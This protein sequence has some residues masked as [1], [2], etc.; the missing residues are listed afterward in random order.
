MRLG[1]IAGAAALCLA[2]L[3]GSAHA[4]E[5]RGRIVG[6]VVD[7]SGAV[8]P[9]VS[10]TV[11]GP[12]L[13]QPQTATS[14]ADGTYRFPSLPSG[15]YTVTYEM[16]GFQTTRREGIRVLLN[17]TFTVDA[18]LQLA[19]VQEALTVT[20]E[21][22]TVD[23]KTTS[24]GTSFTKELL[25]D[26]PNARDVWAAMAQ[27][28]GFQM[29]G[30]DVGGSH[31]GTQTGYF[32][33]GIDNQNK[34]LLEGI[35][36]TES[37]NAN[38]GYF[39]FGSFEEF[40]LGGAGNL[41][42]Q[43]GPGALMNI[44]VKSGG[45]QF[46]GEVY[47]DYENDGTIADNVPDAFRAPGGVG[48]GGFKAPTILNPET[49][50][51]E[52]LRAGNPITKQYD[53]NVGFGGPIV[54]GKLWFYVGYR[55][56]N[57]YKT[58]LGLPGENAQSKLE[59][60][61][62]KLTYQINPKNQLIGFFNQRTKLQPLRDLSLA[63][64]VETA[65]YQASK[66]RP[67]KLEWTSVVS[68]RVFLDVQVAHW[69][70]AFPLY[71]SAT[72][73]S[74]T[75]GVPVGRI[76]L[77][78]LQQTG[79]NNAYQDQFRYKPQV[80]A[81]VSYFAD[82]WGP[83]TH[84]FKLGADW[85]RDRKQFLSFQPGDIY[86]RDR[87]GVT[88]EV[89]I[90]NT[91]N[92]SVNDAVNLAAYLNDSWSLSRRFTLNWSLRY[93]RYA[94][95]WPAQGFTPNQATF[96]QSIESPQ[97]DVVTLSSVS[98]R[99]GFAWDLTGKGKTVFKAFFGR[100]YYNPSADVADRE[101]PVGAAQIRYEFKPCTTGQ[102]TGCDLNG[103]KLVDGRNELGRELQRLGGA[104]FVTID[105]DIDHPYGQELSTHLEHELVPSLS[106]RGS[107][108]YKMTRNEWAEV[109]LARVNAYT[110]PFSFLDIGP[111]NIRGT[112]DDQTLQL[113]DR[114][115][116]AASNR[117]YTNPGKV[118]G[119]PSFD[120]D[121]HTVEF[122]IN[123]RMKDRWLFL[124]SFEH[125]WADDFRNPAQ[126]STSNL[127]TVRQA[128]A[129]LWRPNQRNLGRQ[130][131]TFWNYKL[132]GRYEFPLGF[133][134]AASYK[135]QSGFN[136]ARYVSVTLPN[137]GAENVFMEPMNSNRAPNVHILDF[138][139]EKAFQLGARRG[140]VTAM[141]DIFNALNS[142]V[143]TNFRIVSANNPAAAQ[144]FQ[145][146]IAILDPRAM[147]LGLRWGF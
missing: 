21:S 58:I 7:N 37:T 122:A 85:Q 114:P 17:T 125:T 34:T 139:L 143:T 66:N 91:P 54:K 10:V 77:G 71:P 131:S 108:V 1:R 130:K 65:Y 3:A 132:L 107:Y 110:I 67:V 53:L 83:G 116:D 36:V 27:A 73:S 84:S 26:I 4:Q 102:T 76:D 22:P 39:D 94:L 82:H 68:D 56:N 25:Q 147:R 136:W 121:Y 18:Q 61:T 103:N 24:I 55:N 111:D 62:G 64:P 11:A 32:T 88:Q 75:E 112:A 74:S 126:A 35:N 33:Y 20:G 135:L 89:D 101:N 115:R 19:G 52:G 96:F 43:A 93:D 145:E 127:G 117:V 51:N 113:F 144:R 59:N 137:A 78:S 87:N 95:G 98:P 48:D 6:T 80:S 16:S 146:V 44:T 46:H 134:L 38:A 97:T 109:D 63:I 40:Q 124:T 140:K 106:L 92:D 49:H 86:Y 60:W 118:A 45:D 90:W 14:G 8:L 128:T 69:Y 72:K 57:Q 29:Q 9:G 81:N 133:S 47:F 30:Y 138:R 100:Y 28:P 142:D 41:G 104:G 42:E 23:V 99:L 12:A 31:T 2:A 5:L 13:M 129:F 105:R 50:Q 79:A 141:L 120:G 15:F 70:N 123:R 119:L